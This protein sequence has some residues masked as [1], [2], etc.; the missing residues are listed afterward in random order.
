M[1]EGFSAITSSYFS[2]GNEKPQS[3]FSVRKPMYKPINVA[4][5][6]NLEPRILF[7]FFFTCEPYG[8]LKFSFNAGW[9][10]SVHRT[11]HRFASLK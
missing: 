4:Y 6:S 5:M 1:G 2:E 10:G 11:S 7:F 8:K 3:K 9:R